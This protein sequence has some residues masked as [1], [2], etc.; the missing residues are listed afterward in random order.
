MASSFSFRF[1]G[2]RMVKIHPMDWGTARGIIVA[3]RGDEHHT[4]AVEP[5]WDN[6][7]TTGESL[8]CSCGFKSREFSGNGAWQAGHDG[9]PVE[10][11]L[12]DTHR[13]M[14]DAV[15]GWERLQPRLN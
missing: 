2:L 15:S 6:D 12:D 10:H 14:R 1:G 9:P 7:G 8:V 3:T 11:F 13:V 5:W 4:M